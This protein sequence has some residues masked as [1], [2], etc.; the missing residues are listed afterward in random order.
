MECN[1]VSRAMLYQ[2]HYVMTKCVDPS[3]DESGR[4]SNGRSHPECCDVTVGNFEILG[5]GDEE[6]IVR[7]RHNRARRAEHT[8][9]AGQGVKNH[10]SIRGCS[11]QGAEDHRLKAVTKE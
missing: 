6:G 5:F 2:I 9:V 10:T 4:D 1:K 7:R 3:Q 8:V 11:M